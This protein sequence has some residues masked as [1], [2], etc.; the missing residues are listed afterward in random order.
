MFDLRD[1]LEAI[2]AYVSANGGFAFWALSFLFCLVF[3]WLLY[4]S[5]RTNRTA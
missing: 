5:D 1:A 3:T 2:R 4:L